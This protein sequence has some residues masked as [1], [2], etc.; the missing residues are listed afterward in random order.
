MFIKQNRKIVKT[1]GALMAQLGCVER[2]DLR[3][4]WV[5]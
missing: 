3:Q 1:A 4:V 2:S 5:V